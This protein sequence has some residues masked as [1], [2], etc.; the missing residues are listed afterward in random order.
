MN[1]KRSKMEELKNR[2]NECLKAGKVSEAIELYTEAINLEPTAALY[3]NRSNA[4][5]KLE[6][7]YEADRDAQQAIKLNPMWS[8][9]YFRFGEVRNSIGQY[10]EAMTSYQTAQM[11]HQKQEGRTDPLLVQRMLLTHNCL[12]QQRKYGKN[13][14]WVCAGVGLIAAVLIIV[15]DYCLTKTPAITHVLVQSVFVVVLSALGGGAGKV[16]MWYK[17]HLRS[18]ML[19]PTIQQQEELNQQAEQDYDDGAGE[20]AEEQQPQRHHHRYTKA[21]ARHRFKKGKS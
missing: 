5:L 16:W 12:Q 21:Q 3:S 10:T 4:Y 13:M 2:G 6:K 1:C 8:K 17:Q 14:P 19:Q 20:A 18:T 15:A 9:G 11:L 7:Y